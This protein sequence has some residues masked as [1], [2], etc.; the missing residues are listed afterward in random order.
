MV[1]EPILARFLGPPAIGPP[2][3]NRSAIIFSNKY[4]YFV[5]Q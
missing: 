1:S 5:V 2:L 3:N 4:D